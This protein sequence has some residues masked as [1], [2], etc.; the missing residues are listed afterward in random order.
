M[1]IAYVPAFL[2]PTDGSTLAAVG[3]TPHDL[4]IRRTTEPP[5]VRSVNAVPSTTRAPL[6]NRRGEYGGVARMPSS[7]GTPAT[8]SGD[9]LTPNGERGQWFTDAA[10]VSR[11]NGVDDR[12]ERR[13]YYPDEE[14]VPLSTA[15]L[16]AVEAHENASLS[17]DELDLFR[18]VDPDAIDM[19][20]TNTTDHDVDISVQFNLADV[21]IS[22]WNDG[23]I[24]IRVTERMR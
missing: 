1:V 11:M 13:R 14:N 2:R 20:F 6:K 21:T 22:V 18:Y 5:P 23:G 8:D 16:E 17:G 15:I 19:L 7:D 4:P 3:L 10:R 24:D 12:P 9:T